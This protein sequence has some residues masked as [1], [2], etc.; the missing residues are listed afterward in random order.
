VARKLLQV[1]QMMGPRVV[2]GTQHSSQ[3][4]DKRSDE[5]PE[6]PAGLTKQS[7][8]EFN[9]IE[10][11]FFV[12]RSLCCDSRVVVRKPFYLTPFG[13][14]QRSAIFIIR[15]SRLAIRDLPFTARSRLPR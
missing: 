5:K 10:S 12:P 1:E 6:Q 14:A 13:D 8:S 3:M 4:S 2:I 7:D 15:E 9:V 11:N